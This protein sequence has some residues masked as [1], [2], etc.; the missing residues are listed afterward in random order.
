[1]VWEL[2]ASGSRS[3]NSGTLCQCETFADI[4]WK[5]LA[6][7]GLSFVASVVPRYILE[8]VSDSFAQILR[9]ILWV[10]EALVFYLSWFW[11]S[12]SD[13]NHQSNAFCHV[14]DGRYSSLPIQNARGIFTTAWSHPSLPGLQCT[15]NNIRRWFVLGALNA[16]NF[17]TLVLFT[18]SFVLK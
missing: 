12:E 17:L 18:W 7:S 13:L 8:R 3:C 14:C 4:T 9:Y 16:L 10:F 2:S 15:G 11:V 6:V 1:M 5:C